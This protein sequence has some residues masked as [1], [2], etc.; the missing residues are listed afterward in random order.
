MIDF[1]L[2]IRSDQVWITC[3]LNLL[4][5]TSKGQKISKAF[6]LETLLPKKGTKY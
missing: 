3:F 6:F 4:F 2:K 1:D 5:T